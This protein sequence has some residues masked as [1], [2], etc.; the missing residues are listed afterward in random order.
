[1]TATTEL[2]VQCQLLEMPVCSKGDVT[3]LI[4]LPH[5]RNCVASITTKACSFYDDQQKSYLSCYLTAVVL[6]MVRSVWTTV[7][8]VADQC[9][10]SNAWLQYCI[11]NLSN[12][13]KISGRYLREALSEAA[14]G[15]DDCI[16]LCE[17]DKLRETHCRWYARGLVKI[18]D[19]RSS[20][21]LWRTTYNGFP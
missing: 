13:V 9:P 11:A 7:E 21:S 14:R 10:W 12:L 15:A 18:S 19:P 4:S 20:W 6:S 16:I 8:T 5:Q 1:M 17:E 2:H 3:S